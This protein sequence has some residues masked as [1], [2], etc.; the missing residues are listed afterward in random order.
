M[1]EYKQK[2]EK[3]LADTNTKLE[4]VKAIPQRSPL[5]TK[6]GEMHGINYWVTLANEKHIYGFNFWGSIAD[7]EKVMHGEG[8]GTKPNAYDI[9]T[10]LSNS[11]NIGDFEDFCGNFGYDTDSITAE[12]TYKAVLNESENI[13][14]LWT[15]EE[16]ETLAEIN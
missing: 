1:N 6:K 15:N 3:F 2:A 14:K 10:C 11:I 12:K 9:L 13:N 4:V 8:H 16:L 5:W 7:K